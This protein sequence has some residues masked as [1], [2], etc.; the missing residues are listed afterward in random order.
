MVNVK[1]DI[2]EGPFDLLVYLIEKDKVDIYDI[3]IADI[4]RQYCDYIERMEK[5]NLE[6]MSEFLLL[7]ATLIEI[8]SK[9]LL[10]SSFQAEAPEGEEREDPRMTLVEKILEYKKFKQLAEFFR[11]KE[12]QSLR[13][14]YKVQEDFDDYI[15][16][17][18]REYIH[19]DLDDFVKAFNLFLHKKKKLYDIRKNYELI[20]GEKINVEKKTEEIKRRFN[21]KKRVSFY[22]LLENAYDRYELILTFSIILELVK[23]DYFTASQKNTFGDIVLIKTIGEEVNG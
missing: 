10:P 20:E 18:N 15:D 2:F 14:K 23:Q 7:A 11:E 1:L 16:G 21:H 4:T 17:E 19:I 13:V 22:E 12:E 3:P 8:K 5:I 9:M 6:G